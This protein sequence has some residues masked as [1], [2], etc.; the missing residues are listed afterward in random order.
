MANQSSQMTRAISYRKIAFSVASLFAL[1]LMLAKKKK[2][3]AILPNVT[4]ST[5]I[6]KYDAVKAKDKDYFISSEAADCREIVTSKTGVASK[7]PQT[8]IQIFSKA[9][10]NNPNDPA[11][12]SM[13]GKTW[14]WK[15]YYD[16]V[17]IASKA[18]LV[19]GFDRY[20]T[21]SIIGFNSP[22]WVIGNMAA[23]FA[24]GKSAGIYTT[25]SP[26]SVKY[27]VNHSRSKVAFVENEMQLNKFK[28]AGSFDTLKVIVVWNSTTTENKTWENG[29]QVLSWKTFMDIGKKSESMEALNSR[30]F[31]VQPGHC[32][33]LIYTSGTTGNPKAVMISHDNIIYETACVNHCSPFIGKKDEHIVSYLPLSHVAGQMVDIVTPIYITGDLEGY[34]TVHFASPTALKGSLGQTL[35]SVRPTIFLGVPRV[36]EKIQELMKSKSKG[37][38]GIKLAIATWAKSKGLEY[39]KNVQVGGSGET[40]FLHNLAEKL[41]FSKVKAALGLDRC[42]FAFS[43]AAPLPVETMKYFASLGVHIN[44]VYGMSEC[45]GASTWSTNDTH[46]WGS[47]GF[48]IPG[49]EI[50]VAHDSSRGD[51]VGEGELCFRGRNVMMGYL[52]D[53]KKTREAIDTDGWLHSGDVGRRDSDGMYFITG[54]IKELIVTHGG[55]NIA[56]VPIEDCIKVNCPALSNVMMVGDK[57]KYNVCLV[58]LKSG[59]DEDGNPT[60]NLMAEAQDVDPTVRTVAQAQSSE[61]WKKYIEKGVKGYNKG[62]ASNAQ[63]IQ[64]FRI[65][66][67]DFSVNGG[68]F[69]ATLKLKRPIATAMH[70][71]L[72]ESMYK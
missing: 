33:V 5:D 47:V 60:Q 68:E 41:I 27:I 62:A 40:P 55:E 67:Q 45:C 49:L 69:T 37:N 42:H 61:V 34:A 39:S 72:I 71:D 24:G 32:A 59:A 21:A 20:D 52:Y 43:G 1:Y 16:E 9:V 12:I 8:L 54:R 7:E 66:D 64:Y 17:I 48:A 14:T 38:A 31:G 18:L 58:T 4:S 19:L 63:K 51:K 56:P 2:H 25:N 13:D 36:W 29:I 23:I 22:E 3:K 30:M 46:K 65:V 57:R 28:E 70:A 50:K 6:P 15:Q 44:E 10:A 26:D 53:E 35:K 11:L